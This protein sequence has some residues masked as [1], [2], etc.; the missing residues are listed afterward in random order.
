ME[1]VVATCMFG[2]PN[3]LHLLA[4]TH[5]PGLIP[6]HSNAQ[7]AA[8][9][10]FTTKANEATAIMWAARYGRADNVDAIVQ[11]RASIAKP[12]DWTSYEGVCTSYLMAFHQLHP[13]W[14]KDAL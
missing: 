1:A 4:K 7:G 6:T 5:C 12:V 3:I 2:P 11:L 13:G 14:Q 10:L 8:E 9:F